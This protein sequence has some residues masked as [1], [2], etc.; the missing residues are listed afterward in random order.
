YCIPLT[1]RPD[2][3]FS[4]A[5]LAEF[6]RESRI[7]FR[8]LFTGNILSQPAFRHIKR[9]IY[10]SLRNADLTSTNSLFI[11]CYPGITHAMREYVCERL[12][13]F[14]DKKMR[15]HRSVHSRSK[16]GLITRRM[17]PVQVS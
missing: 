8:Y 11:G 16:R 4:R 2:A 9:R 17:G 15:T 12:A 1:I 13:S 10:G 6:L 14:L 3:G 5:E 7:E